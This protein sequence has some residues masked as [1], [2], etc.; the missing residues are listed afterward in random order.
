MTATDNTPSER[1]ALQLVVRYIPKNAKL[2]TTAQMSY[3]ERIGGK[4]KMLRLH[5]I[6]QR[7]FSP[8]KP[9]TTIRLWRAMCVSFESHS[10][11][12][13]QY[14]VDRAAVQP[15][16]PAIISCLLS[17]AGIDF[18][19]NVRRPD[20]PHAEQYVAPLPGKATHGP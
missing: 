19:P 2:V 13:G 18:D 15:I 7:R 1:I 17:E 8:K 10:V 14:G 9:D 12:Q 11:V 6:T 16:M 3:L 4:F 5:F 20:T